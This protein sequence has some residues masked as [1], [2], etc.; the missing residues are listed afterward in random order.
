MT[1]PNPNARTFKLRGKTYR[2]SKADVERAV[3]KVEPRSTEKYAVMIGERAFPPKQLIEVSL[4]LPPM[5]F[6]TMDAQRI[7]TRLG[8]E[9]ISSDRQSASETALQALG[10]AP[11][12]PSRSPSQDLWQLAAVGSQDDDRA[13]RLKNWLR[14]TWLETRAKELFESYLFASS[15]GKSAL[16]SEPQEG[17]AI[18]DFILAVRDRRIAL[19]VKELVAVDFDIASEVELYDPCRPVRDRI[20]AAEYELGAMVEASRCLVL[21][22]RC[23]PWPIFDWRLIYG[24][25]RDSGEALKGNSNARVDEERKP[26]QSAPGPLDAVIVLEQLRTGYLR[27]KAHVRAQEARTGKPLSESEYLAELHRARGTERDFILSRLRVIVHEN[28][29]GSNPLPKDVF[30]G[31]YDEWYGTA[32]D[33]QIDRTFVGDE[34][35][36]LEK[37]GLLR[38]S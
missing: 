10:T 12:S 34:I 9:V 30:R 36:S 8:F 18:P 31:P 25:M 16:R 38:A 11:M 33:G 5:A 29:D 14:D 15:L 13:Q 7:L 17:G 35:R 37:D 26:Q 20:T 24:A 27:F 28:P 19:E 3:A 4:H 6:T 23:T 21:Y 22:S 1:S 32:K 2:L